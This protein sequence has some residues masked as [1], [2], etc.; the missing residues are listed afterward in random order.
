[1]TKE[2]LLSVIEHYDIVLEYELDATPE[3][4]DFSHIMTERQ[5]K[6]NQ[7]AAAIPLMKEMIKDWNN[8]ESKIRFH[9]WLAFVQGV[10]WS[11]GVFCINDLRDHSING[12]DN[13]RFNVVPD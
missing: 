7:C 4:C 3:F 8:E 2:K 12:V 13:S 11:E 10:L 5:V 6:F 1:M 9:R